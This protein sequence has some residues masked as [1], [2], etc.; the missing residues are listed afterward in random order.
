MWNKH[1]TSRAPGRCIRTINDAAAFVPFDLPPT[2]EW[3]DRLVASVASAHS[4]MGSL[5]GLGA[6]F[7]R[8]NRLVR[9]FLRREA[10]YSSRIEQ[11]FAGVR[12]LVLFDF[13]DP[14]R[15]EPAAREVENNYRLLEQAFDSA[16]TQ[17][18]SLS[19]IRRMQAVLFQNVEHPPGV[20]GEFRKLQNWIGSSSDIAHARYVPPPPARV[21]ECMES[22]VRFLR[23]GGDL[24][25]LVRTALAHYYFEAVHPFDDGNG[26]VGRAM[27]LTQLVSEGALP[28]PLLNPSAQLERRRREYYDLLL[29]VTVA[30]QWERW[31]EFFCNCIA[32]EC[33]ASTRVLGRLEAL[34]SDY[35]NRIG[36]ARLGGLMGKLVDLLF[37]EPATNARLAAAALGITRQAALRVL[38][39]LVN[40]GILREVTGKSRNRVFLAEAVVAEFTVPTRGASRK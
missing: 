38:G 19:A 26:R 16:S 9:M 12:T 23:A 6:R 39:Q 37:G 36:R 30:G 1:L 7:P 11:T 29:D 40:A 28:V 4:A 18:V 24:P 32:T 17:P 34:R 22:L 31:I 13:V 27:I 20:V 8:P 15:Q 35:H 33:E 14:G 21:R 5:A 25:V 2:V 10:E 3:S